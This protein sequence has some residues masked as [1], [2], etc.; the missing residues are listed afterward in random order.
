MDGDWTTVDC[1]TV[2]MYAD[3]CTYIK[4]L[5]PFIN[6]ACCNQQI[7]NLEYDYSRPEYSYVIMMKSKKCPRVRGVKDY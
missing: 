5:R 4:K 7:R 3:V 2:R 6:S 1:N